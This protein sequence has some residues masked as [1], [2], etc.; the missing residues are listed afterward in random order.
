[1]IESDG[2]SSFL[3]KTDFDPSGFCFK[4][5]YQDPGCEFS[6]LM[7]FGRFWLAGF[8]IK[9]RRCL[10]LNYYPSANLRFY[11]CFFSK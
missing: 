4:S 1:M 3:K 2:L 7:L 9:G 11:A 10:F 6:F 8:Q 5:S